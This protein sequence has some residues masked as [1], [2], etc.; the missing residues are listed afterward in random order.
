[1]DGGLDTTGYPSYTVICIVSLVL[2][3]LLIYGMVNSE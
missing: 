1:M 3:A 2:T